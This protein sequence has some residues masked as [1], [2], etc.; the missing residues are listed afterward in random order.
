MKVKIIFSSVSTSD[1]EDKISKWTEESK[2][3]IISVN[4]NCNVMNDYY[5][6]SAPPM[7]CNTWH[8]YI[9]SIVYN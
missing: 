6:D 9:A 7:V 2:P 5:Q 8:E 4:V 3:N 1:L